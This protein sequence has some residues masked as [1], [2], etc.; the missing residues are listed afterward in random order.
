M[1]NK[2]LVT[3]ATGNVG[4]HIIRL[5]QDKGVDFVAGVNSGT[6]EDVASVSIEY[7]DVASLEKAMQGIST[8]FMV[9]PDHPDVVRWGRN[10]I[11]TAKNAG[12]N[13]IVRLSGSLAKIDSSLKMIVLLSATDQDVKD[14]GI[15]YT[16]TAPQFFMQNFINYFADDYKNGTICQSA[17][18]GKIGWVDL[19][20]V[21][22]VN[23]E[24]LLNPEKYKNQTLTITGSENLSYAEAVSQMNEVLG[25]ESQYIAVSDDTA[26]EA[27]KDL[28]YS[29][30]MIDLII[31]LNHSIVE[32]YAEEVN[33]TV[34]CVT[35]KTHITFKQ[36]VTDNKDVWSN[37]QT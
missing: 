8:L 10:L 9:L 34:E 31:S 17:G 36:F 23:V 28:K 19:R 18:D 5:L 12:V 3:G 22:A 20:D 29:P 15:D 37:G 27:M 33:D 21:A 7:T 6:I 32:G 30:F 14:S 11:D 35:G 24:V 25:K 1:S 26:I 13:H 4:S 16:I 2:I